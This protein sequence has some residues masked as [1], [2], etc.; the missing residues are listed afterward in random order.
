MSSVYLTTERLS[1]EGVSSNT[2]LSVLTPR[3]RYIV[4][5]AQ[6]RSGADIA[7]ELGISRPVV[8]AVARRALRRLRGHKKPVKKGTL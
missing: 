2:D 5:E 7:R 1:I 8:Y 6:R 4:T 3:E